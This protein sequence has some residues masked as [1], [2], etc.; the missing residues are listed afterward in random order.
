MPT[1]SPNRDINYLSKD[2]DSIKSDLIDYVKRHFPNEWRDFNDASGGMAILDMMAYIGDILSF[3]IDR[4]VNEAY[5]NR[6]IETKNIVSL[7]ENFGYTPRNNTPAVVT[8]A[9]SADFTTSTSGN[10]LCRLKKGAKIF[11]NYEPVVPF[12]ILTDVDF[13]QA[14]NRVVNPDNAGVTTVSISSVSAS[15]GVT[16]TFSYRADSPIKFLKITL[17]DTNV[18]EI[19]SVSSVDGAFYHQVDSLAQDTVF[20][21]QI[22]GDANT[23]GDAAY[24]L[25]I[26]RVPKRYTVEREPTG[27]TSVR[28]GPG[29]LTEADTEIIPN[30]NDFV[31]PPTLRGSPSGFTASTIDSTN[32]LKTQSLGVAPRNTTLV[33]TYRQGGGVNGNVGPKSLTRF[34]EK[35]VEFITPNFSNDNAVKSR[36][37]F[38]SIACSNSNQASGGEEG[39]SI[40]SIKINAINNMA[41]QMRCVT[42]QDYQ[43]RIMSMPSQFGSVFRSFAR[44]DPNNNLG[45][46]LFLITRNATGQLSTPN[47]I[48]KNN[49][50]KYIKQFKSFSDSVKFSAGR[51]INIGVEFTIVPSPDA[52]YAES[53][54]DTILLMQRQFD[55][56]RTN[57]NDTIVISQIISLIQAQ[58]SVL[59]VPD[60]R[61][62][63]KTGSNSG[64][65]Y[66]S[67][68]YNINANTTSGILSFGQR[69]VWELKYPNYDIVGRPAD[70]STAAAQ[71]VAGGTAGGG[72]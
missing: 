50:E 33:V 11:T 35:E 59:S 58:K 57:F 12:E 65:T 6:A 41:S 64:R 44:K 39:E 20:I 27:L 22:N 10:E 4:Q 47:G 42:L 63:N 13:S 2:F 68:A 69:D 8:L 21:G 45:V 72:Y 19:V 61:I 51:I 5:I 29:I 53:L 9:V 31:L 3:N 71:G 67:A 56:A 32:F 49:I 52:N 70:Q 54:M 23:S 1:Q 40:A 18:N 43:V 15:A 26:K 55:T 14:H 7:A 37:I 66:S 48:I 17:P 34:V 46:E 62:V 24:V 30:P 16:K 28:F 25:K 36:T 60:F 38:D